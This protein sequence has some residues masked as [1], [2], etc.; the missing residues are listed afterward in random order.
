MH[1]GSHTFVPMSWMCKKMTSVSHISTESEI[2]YLEAGLR[3][4]GI[5]A[6]HLWDLVFALSHSF[7]NQAQKNQELVHGDPLHNKQSGNTP[8]TQIKIQI[9]KE[10]H[11]FSGVD[12]VASNVKSPRPGATLYIFLR[13]TRQ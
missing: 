3:M 6:L 7:P 5:P 1:L 4:D 13:T 12:Y 10:R 2:V 9:P 8:N 11:E